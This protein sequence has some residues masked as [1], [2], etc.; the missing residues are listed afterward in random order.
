[1][2]GRPLKELMGHSKVVLL[3]IALTYGHVAQR[4]RSNAATAFLCRHK[5]FASGIAMMSISSQAT[6]CY[7]LYTSFVPY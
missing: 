1:M 2:F 4:F 3:G 6:D 5:V 7:P